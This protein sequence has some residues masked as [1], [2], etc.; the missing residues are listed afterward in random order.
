[1]LSSRQKP[2]RS[3]SKSLQWQPFSQVIKSKF[4]ILII[5]L[6]LVSNLAF[7]HSFASCSLRFISTEKPVFPKPTH[8]YSDC[9]VFSPLSPSGQMSTHLPSPNSNMV[10]PFPKLV[11]PPLCH[12]GGLHATQGEHIL[13]CTVIVYMFY[14]QQT[15]SPS[16]LHF[17]SI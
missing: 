2:Y 15:M 3:L 8:L 10:L 4:L 13:Q 6:G 7:C 1:M 11:T 9:H 17:Q 12:R 16:P 5:A 14:T